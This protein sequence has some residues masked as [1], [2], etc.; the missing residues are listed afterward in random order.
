MT[1]RRRCPISRK[2]VEFCRGTEFYTS[3]QA[4]RA[5]I[6]LRFGFEIDYCKGLDAAPQTQEIETPPINL[7]TEEVTMG[8][9]KRKVSKC[10]QCGAEKNTCMHYGKNVCSGCMSMRI[11]AKN[12]PE[13]VLAALAEF[14]HMPKPVQLVPVEDTGALLCEIETLKKA[15]GEKD[16]TIALFHTTIQSHT[17]DNIDN[18]KRI[19]SLSELVFSYQKTCLDIAVELGHS[20]ATEINLAAEVSFL[21]QEKDRLQELLDDAIAE[22][23]A[24][25]LT[26]KT[27]QPTDPARAGVL[28]DIVMD[29]MAGKITGLDVGRLQ[30]LR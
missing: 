22:L 9:V 27:P 17:L 3:C 30:A 14:G 12:K 11:A 5:V 1:G 23:D 6:A 13:V 2:P 15:V 7:Q 18:E 29:A 21:K 28:L 19:T 24:L 26:A 20:S 10:D 25:S 8:A 16:A 4:F